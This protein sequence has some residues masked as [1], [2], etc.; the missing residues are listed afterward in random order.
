DSGR[1]VQATVICGRNRAARR[2]LLLASMKLENPGV[3]DL[4]IK[5]H[6][7][8]PEMASWM[9][10]CDLLV[11]KP[12][13]LTTTEALAA[14]CPF[15]VADPFMIPGQEEGNADFLVE[16]GIGRRVHT[17]SEAAEAILELTSQPDTLAK[18]SRQALT[19]A[20]P[21]ASATIID[22]LLGM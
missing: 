13:G 7:S 15:L 22:R 11:S 14:G 12:G 6:V 18:M 4:V 1:P 20:K 8:Q 10:A 16:A 2:R 5:G 19:H 21:G 9:H 3:F 17:P